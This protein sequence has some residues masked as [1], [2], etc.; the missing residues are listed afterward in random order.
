[1][2]KN[3]FVLLDIDGVLIQPGG[4]RRSYADTVN[5]Y[6]T[7]LGQ[8]HLHV[9]DRIA[10]TFEFF[11]I[12]AEWDMVPL[13][14]AAFLEWFAEVRGEHPNFI[15][16]DQS[17][18]LPSIGDQEQFLSFL[19]NKII[20]YSK[21]LSNKE[22][23]AL[24]IYHNCIRNQQHSVLPRIWNDP[25]LEEILLNSLDIYR[26][27]LFR[28]LETQLLGTE[29]MNNRFQLNI[30]EQIAPNLEVVDFPIL[31][32]EHRDRLIQKKDGFH[33]AILTAR[34]NLLPDAIG[35]TEADS[36]F[37]LPEAEIAFRLIGWDEHAI[38]V[39]GVGSLSY[40]ENKYHL[41]KD[42]FLKPHPFHSIASILNTMI[43]SQTEALET[44]KMV[45]DRWVEG[46]LLS[47]P[48]GQF[49]QE[50]SKIRIAVFEDSAS[51][52]QS[53]I[54]AGKI[55]SDY[56]YY[57]EIEAY[58]IYS[59]EEKK[60]QLQNLGAQIYPNVNEALDVF[61]NTTKAF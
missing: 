35:A 41:P 56:G 7:F 40:I 31:S 12:Q 48:L 32:E 22:I 6:L 17:G 54:S 21:A 2:R 36:H 28:R 24:A 60:L 4:Y 15:S 33:T 26:S 45:Y 34:P 23:P 5:Y 59:T 61:F 27:P 20:D 52:I 18:N 3:T 53:C 46:N 13:T 38:P 39:I 8:P 57:P 16:I 42:S 1:M 30:Q 29:Y 50:G 44:A 58:G 19:K 25:I 14:I 9:N 49:I 37:I 43:Q 10:E 55:F 51:G 11:S 47:N